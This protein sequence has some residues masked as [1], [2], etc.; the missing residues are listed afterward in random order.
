MFLFYIFM[1]FLGL[2][3]GSFLNVVICRLETGETMV[4][5]RS[6]C[7]RCGHILAWYDLV[8][9]FSFLMLKGKCRYCGKPI[10]IQY[11]MVEMATGILFL[12]IFNYQFSIFI[13]FTILKFSNIYFNEMESCLIPLQ[14][15]I[16]FS[17]NLAVLFS[18]S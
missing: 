10:S 16:I 11:P 12:S 7:P 4:S 2:I 1:F 17:P 6:H 15:P 5:G 8:P 18:R 14:N 9:V 3:A 13:E